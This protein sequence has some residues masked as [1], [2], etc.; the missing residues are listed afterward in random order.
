MPVG[1]LSLKNNLINF[2]NPFLNLQSMYRFPRHLLFSL[3]II[4]LILWLPVS[5]EAQNA[6]VRGFVYEKKSG[7][8]VIFTNVYLK[9]TTY[10]AVTDVNGYF[11]IPSVPPGDYTLMVTFV[12]YDTLALPIS[13]KAGEVVN[14]KLY[15]EERAILLSG[16]LISAE[17]QEAKTETKTSVAK[18]TPKQIKQ[19]PTIGGQPDL[20]QYL[21]VLPGV[22]FTG[23]QG[24]QL[25][26]RGGS[27]VQN[28]V[29]MDGA[30]IYNP[31]HSIGLFSV[32]ETDIIRNADIYTGGFNAEYGGRI[33]SVMDITTRDGNKKRVAGKAGASTFGARLLVEGPL[34]KQTDEG[35]SSSFIFSFKNSYLS[36][37]SK[38]FYSYVDP[39]GLPF[40]Y[41][42]LYGKLSFNSANGSKVNFF[43]FSY[44]DKVNYEDISDFHWNSG[45]GGSNF[46]VIPER[47]PVIMQGNFAYSTYNMTLMESD[48]LPRE[49][50]I[51]GFNAGLGFNYILSRDELRYGMDMQG[52]KTDFR[53]YNSVNRLI[54]QT[55]N[56]TELGAFVKYKANLGKWIIEPGF[57]IQWYASLADLSP[58]PRLA[59]K[60]RV[61]DH[62]RLKM[63]TGLYSQNLI[64]AN[65]DKDVVNLFYGF[66]SGPDNLPSEFDGEEITH[67]LQKAGHVVMGV[68]YDIFKYISLNFEAYYKNFTQLT[69]LNRNKVYDDTDEY[70]DK[71]DE[72]KKDFVIET[73]KAYG[74]DMSIKYDYKNFYFWGTYS[75]GYVDRYNGAFHYPT[76]YDRRHNVN[77]VGSVF[78]GEDKQW[79]FDIRWNFGSGF[80]FTK[81]AGYYGK[82]TFANGINTDYTTS[83]EELGI[84][85][86]V[87]NDGR[88]PTYHRMDVNLKRKIQLRET[89]FLEID[90]SVTNVYD[91]KNVFYFDRLKGETVYQL[92]VLPSLGLT[93]IF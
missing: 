49:S 2:G 53:F 58:E 3:F 92:P 47:S 61:N 76:H 50:S 88:L 16:A 6:S 55:D 93:L 39:E 67:K 87:I 71:P 34:K 52:F 91:R 28:K 15:V 44:N 51:K 36:Q 54:E 63:A 13:L 24:G 43:G 7:E 85:Y 19:I 84:Q 86:D 1:I 21:Q 89:T 77:L 17:K 20:A 11:L 31:F 10:G 37:S 78:W 30:I 75:L 46:L 65:S 69:N 80:P 38:V 12:G 45:G 82:L 25:Y 68:E 57:R 81:T 73:G 56:T 70:W 8:P 74:I 66:I 14:K 72:L 9:K 40:D 79:Q 29:I 27:P 60:Y 4:A 59:M 22:I 62:V 33:S 26:I 64:S 5:V 90:A 18:I 83:N 32:F 23:D 42:D 41:T 35:S 48:G